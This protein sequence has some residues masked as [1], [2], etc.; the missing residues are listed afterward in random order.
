M[1]T[2]ATDFDT[3]LPRP[4]RGPVAL[5]GSGEYTP[6]MDEADRFLLA[7]LGGPER[8]RVALLPTASG[9]EPGRPAYWNDLGVQHFRGLG[10][11]DVRPADLL[12]GDDARDPAKIAVLREAT[13]FYFSGGDPLHLIESLRGSPAWALIAEA[14]AQGAVLAGCSAG[15]MALGGFTTAPRRLAGA[16]EMRLQEALGVVRGIAVLPHFDRMRAAWPDALEQVWSAAPDGAILLGIDEETA[17]VQRGG[18]ERAHDRIWRVFGRQ[19]VTVQ[20]ASS[21]TRVLRAGEEV[22]L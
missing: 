15:A 5:V 19:S 13:F 8:A 12:D 20:R 16:G 1:R 2:S 7:L 3:G 17:L 10:V 21:P 6:A 22:A 18:A 14:H 9:R 4:L 11:R